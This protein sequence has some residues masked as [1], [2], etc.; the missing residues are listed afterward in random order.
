MVMQDLWGIHKSTFLHVIHQC[1]LMVLLNIHELCFKVCFCYIP[2]NVNLVVIIIIISRKEVS[3][4]EEYPIFF[5]TR[6]L[7][8]LTSK[9]RVWAKKSP[10]REYG[11]WLCFYS[12]KTSTNMAFVELNKRLSWCGSWRSESSYRHV[13]S[14]WKCRF[15]WLGAIG[16]QHAWGM[17]TYALGTWNGGGL[18]LT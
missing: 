16:N 18:C 12:S 5:I 15:N 14:D 4:P 11:W 7:S 2:V 9:R 6:D 10:S 17:L 1:I 3:F 8:Q 13:C